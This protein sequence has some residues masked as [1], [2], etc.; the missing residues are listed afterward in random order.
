[1]RWLYANPGYK[2]LALAIALG[3]WGLSH[4]SSDEERGIEVPV[5]ITG[6]PEDLVVTE[7]SAEEVNLRVMGTRAA[8]RNLAAGELEYPIDLSGAKPGETVV[9]VEAESLNLPRG[10]RVV[11]RSPSQVALSLSRRGSRSVEVRVDVEG[12]PA[13]GHRITAVEV[14]PPRVRI[15][16]AR[17]EVL[18]LSAV[19]TE[20]VDVNGAEADV[21]REVR[22]SLG[23]GNVWLE[24]P[25][26]IQVKVR[27]ATEPTEAEGAG[28]EPEETA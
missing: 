10:T 9:E 22:L 15:T 18:R 20:T 24:E 1:M 6:V 23:Q 11:R 16:G 26:K 3:L 13:E 4:S 8:L 21:E 25:T 7:K 14:E 12:E 17:A 19:M 5:V 2:L 28:A 27:I